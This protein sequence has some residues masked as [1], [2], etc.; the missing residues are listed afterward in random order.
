MA[1]HN[2]TKKPAQAGAEEVA[3]AKPKKIGVKKPGRSPE[4]RDAEKG[5]ETPV[6][7]LRLYIAGQTPKSLTAIANLKKICEEHLKGQY[8]IKVIDLLQK[9]QLAQGEQILAIPTLVRKEPNK[10]IIGDLSSTERVLIWLGV[11]SRYN[12]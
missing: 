6:Y 9:P 3:G 1:G 10:K 12:C 2:P 8:R 7:D 4:T 5:E 11:H